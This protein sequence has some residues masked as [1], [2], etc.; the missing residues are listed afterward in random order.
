MTV[1]AT[2]DAILTKQG[3]VAGV[4]DF[5]LDS[6]G[7]IATADFFDTAL[8]MSL[9]C[10]R[11]ASGSEVPQ[12]RFRNG[13]IG[14]ESNSDGFE[15]GSK[16]WLFQQSR[17][18]NDTLNGI[19]SAAREGLQWLLDRKFLDSITVTTTVLNG[20]V[21]LQIDLFRPNS[22]VDRRFFSLWDASGVT[23]SEG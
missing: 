8:L 17:L 6:T 12:S 22:P 2:T 21:T 19:T 16:I 20:A 7:D 13:W 10:K 3:P 14:N 9:F 18:D 4:W 15:I 5:T 23:S 1:G 11:R